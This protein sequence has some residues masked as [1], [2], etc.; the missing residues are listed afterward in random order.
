MRDPIQQLCKVLVDNILVPRSHSTSKMLRLQPIPVIILVFYLCISINNILTLFIMTRPVHAG[1]VNLYL[2]INKL[3]S[4]QSFTCM[5]VQR[6]LSFGQRGIQISETNEVIASREVTNL[7]IF[8]YSSLKRVEIILQNTYICPVPL[9]SGAY[10]SMCVDGGD[11]VCGSHLA[12]FA[13]PLLETHF[14]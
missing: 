11:T 5:D 14:F 10:E 2:Y 9:P 6:A 4:Y 1:Q 12:I 7:S 13:P 3:V 8:L